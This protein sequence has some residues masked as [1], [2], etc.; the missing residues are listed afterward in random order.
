MVW[1][2]AVHAIAFHFEFQALLMDLPV[3]LPYLG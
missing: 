1:A 2:N 3:D